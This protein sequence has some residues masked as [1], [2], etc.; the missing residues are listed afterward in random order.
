MVTGIPSLEMPDKL[1]E[2]Y[3]VEKHS[4]KSFVS[5]MPMRS[6]CILKVVHSDVCGPFEKHI[7]G[8][9]RYFLS[10]FDEFSQKL[11]IYVIKRKD[12]VFKI[13]KRF[14]MLVKNQSEKKIKMLQT[15]GKYTSKIFEE[16]Y[17]EHGVDHE[18]TAP[19][20]P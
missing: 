13:F 9:N 15:G 1:C 12:G 3:L 4:R 10:L 6:S 5:T 17:V 18:V 11:W 19:Y 2:G 16:F 7:N 14:K 8:G 20:T